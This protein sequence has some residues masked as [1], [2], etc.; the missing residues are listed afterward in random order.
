[1]GVP[2]ANLF[3]RVLLPGIAQ[4]LCSRRCPC[5]CRD[6]AGRRATSPMAGHAQLPAAACSQKESE[7]NHARHASTHGCSTSP[8]TGRVAPGQTSQ[9]LTWTRACW[10]GHRDKPHAALHASKNSTG[11]A[12]SDY[13]TLPSRLCPT[14]ASISSARGLACTCFVGSSTRLA[15]VPP[16]LGRGRQHTNNVLHDCC[17]SQGLRKPLVRQRARAATRQVGAA[18]DPGVP[19]FVVPQC[20]F[21]L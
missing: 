9:A 4:G 8:W 12:V 14:R 19:C 7:C 11:S 18:E 6:D 15:V 3:Y 5:L 20:V 1:M 10:D 2:C 21:C 16:Q 13:T 17:C